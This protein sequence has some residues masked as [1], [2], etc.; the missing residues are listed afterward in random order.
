MRQGDKT[1][2]RERTHVKRALMRLLRSGSEVMICVSTT[3]ATIIRGRES[4]GGGDGRDLCV[5]EYN[6]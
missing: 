2:L 1:T 6:Y 5:V 4:V 3:T